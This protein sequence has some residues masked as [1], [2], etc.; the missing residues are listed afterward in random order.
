MPEIPFQTGVIHPVECY[1]EAWQLIKNDYWLLLLVFIVGALIG[2]ASLYILLGAMAC[3]IF[4]CFL[5]VIDGQKFSFEDLFKGFNFWLPGLIV[6]VFIVVPMLIL[7]GII[8]IPP[9]VAIVSN[10]NIKPEE[11]LGIFAASAV[12][13]AVFA[14]FMV[15]FHTLLIFSFPLI[16]D[17]KLSAF[18]AMKTSA[19]AVWAN[20][21]GVAGLFGI[22]FL[23]SLAGMLVFCIVVYF[24]VPIMVGANVLAYRKIFPAN[25]YGNF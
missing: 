19:K 7:Y 5:R 18:Q 17:K 25:N 1:K 16:V 14:V 22:G 20:L 15:C 8:Y 6:A 24:V 21:S 23:L 13:D 2:G 10:P 4:I 11:L 9:L 3:G 12:V